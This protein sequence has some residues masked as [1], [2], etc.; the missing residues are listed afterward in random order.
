MYR[1]P[2]MTL[3]FLLYNI[4]LLHTVSF[5][6]KSICIGLCDDM[7]KMHC[8]LCKCIDINYGQCPARREFQRSKFDKRTSLSIT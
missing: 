8:H 3:T 7:S 1:G 4:G 6:S 2:N 5:G